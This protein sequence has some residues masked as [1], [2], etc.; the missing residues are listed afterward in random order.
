MYSCPTKLLDRKTLND[1]ETV[2]Q[3]LAWS[4][5]IYIGGGNT[6]EMLDLWK[7]TGF[8][9][10][11]TSIKDE[12]VLSGISAGGNCYFSYSI[13]NYLQME[14][15]DP[16][17]P[18]KELAG[19]SLVDLVFNPHANCTG[20]LASMESVLKTLPQPGISISNNVAIE[21][22]DDEYRLI[23]ATPS[24]SQ[25]IIAILGYWKDDVYYTEEIPE[26]G[27]VKQLPT[28]K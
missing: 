6:K 24:E 2:E 28:K 21:I 5:I 20:R 10:Q 9:K 7:K 23:K 4:D 12:K 11:L 16:N 19:L 27:K 22:I 14:L 13:S 26:R 18:F 17:A 15:N 3:L 8:D 25:E 1:L